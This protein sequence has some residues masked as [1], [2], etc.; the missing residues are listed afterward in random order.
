MYALCILYTGF[1]SGVFSMSK[2]P[3]VHDVKYLCDRL[4][5]CIKRCL[6]MEGPLAAKRCEEECEEHLKVAMDIC[7]L[8][9]YKQLKSKVGRRERRAL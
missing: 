1:V 9:Y 5:E 2:I 7:L 3:V 4:V 6:V 8:E